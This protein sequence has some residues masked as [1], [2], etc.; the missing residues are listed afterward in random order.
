MEASE[1]LKEDSICL[2]ATIFRQT[3]WK[4]NIFAQKCFLTEKTGC[5]IL[6]IGCRIRISHSRKPF[7]KLC[8]K[9]I[10][11]P[12]SGFLVG[13]SSVVSTNTN[14]IRNRNTTQYQYWQIPIPTNTANTNTKTPIAYWYCYI[15]R[16]PLQH[17]FGTSKYPFTGYLQAEYH[18][19][20]YYVL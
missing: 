2:S 12:M 7:V 4:I 6:T 17:V 9:S 10:S 5:I 15:P 20:T 18:S 14:G 3:L 1:E 19:N 11:Q 16:Y 8:G 13:K